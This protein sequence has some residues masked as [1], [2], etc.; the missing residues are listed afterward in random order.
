[1][2]ESLFLKALWSP[3]WD[4]ILGDASTIWVRFQ[5]AVLGAHVYNLRLQTDII[6]SLCIKMQHWIYNADCFILW[7]T[8]F[9]ELWGIGQA[10]TD[11]RKF[12]EPRFLSKVPLDFL[13]AI[14][15]F[16]G[17]HVIQTM[18][19]QVR[20]MSEAYSAA[21]EAWTRLPP[22]K[23]PQ[24]LEIFELLLKHYFNF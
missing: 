17:R 4:N 18:S 24:Q 2:L 14:S 21:S 3:K 10:S 8:I 15:A 16:V 23:F 20:N 19:R 11:S 6:I 5:I 12:Q 7:V 13:V 22:L 1:M 9:S